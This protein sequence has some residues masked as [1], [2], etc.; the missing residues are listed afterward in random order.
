[1]MQE[2]D[3]Y[4]IKFK[5]LSQ[6]NKVEY[7]RV[8]ESAA[9]ELGIRVSTLDD[10][11]KTKQ[12]PSGETETKGRKI[13]LYEPEPWPNPVDGIEILN[14]AAALLSRHMVMR[15]ADVYACVLWAAHTYMFQ[16]FDHS[17][18][19][20]ITAASEEAGKTVLMNH[21]VGNL[22]NRPL[23]VELM[24]P[25]PFFRMIEELHPTFLID[26]CDVFMKEDMDLAAALNSGWE[27][28][29]GVLRCIGD[30]HEVRH[31]ST[32]TPT[33][34][35]G[36]RLHKKLQKSTVGRSL[37]IK[38][39]RAAAG[40]LLPDDAYNRR[41]HKKSIRETGQKIARWINDNRGE[42]AAC[43]PELPRGVRNRL[44]DKWTPLFKIATI[45]GP[46]WVNKAKKALLGEV[47][48]EPCLS[49][50]LLKDIQSI[51]PPEGH[52]HTNEL[53]EAICEIEA[54]PWLH[55][56]STDQGEDSAQITARQIANLLNGYGL[57]P[58]DIKISGINRKGYKREK[59]E[60]AFKRHIPD[61]ILPDDICA[62]PLPTASD[63]AFCNSITATPSEAVA[64]ERPLK[65]AME[66][67]SSAVADKLP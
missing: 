9:S 25:A 63:K 49:L 38:L 31:F 54:N 21:I 12:Q 51:L 43:E 8:R 65:A 35:A 10:L 53:I 5:E 44:Q 40:E 58:E 33:A 30:N 7:D 22:V 26:E 2:Q 50:Q 19:L 16:A 62:T 67:E 66:K 47:E 57:H 37:V 6:L 13:D 41:K 48:T 18:R 27:P 36:I 28:H 20:L 46:E 45:A 1:M 24:K 23:P 15:E 3:D 59:L 17:P 39:E 34:M 60:N 11:V 4:N 29:G 64:D 56:K 61:S 14:E 55:F 42:I 32:F 52:I